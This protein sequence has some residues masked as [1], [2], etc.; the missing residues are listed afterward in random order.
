MANKPRDQ[1]GRVTAKGTQPVVK[2][3][4]PRA[5]KP[6]SDGDVAPD[7]GPNRQ[8]RRQANLPEAPEANQGSGK[9]QKWILIGG[10]AIIAIAT[11]A[12]MVAFHLSGTW[13][14]LLGFAA[15]VATGLAVGASRTWFA[16][17]GRY[18]AIALVAIGLIVTVIGQIGVVAIHWPIFALLGCGLG[19]FFAELTSQQMAPPQA[20]PA[21][22]VALLKRIGAQ[23]IEAPATGGCVW[24]T[25]EGKIRVIIGASPKEATTGDAILVDKSVR[26]S[27]QRGGLLLRR[28]GPM[29]AD[30]GLICV[31]DTAIATTRDEGDVICSA[32]N[33][34]KVL[35][36]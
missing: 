31:V 30:T 29:L 16:D 17:K 25:R 20:P 4:G 36:R 15:G 35:G 3:K 14:G 8:M 18:V 11:I 1:G 2:K 34:T 10:G 7:A 33:L 13:I 32:A 26:K 28:M 6:G 21:S 23:Q 9:R 22:A 27:R 19:A 12:L 24:A 5:G